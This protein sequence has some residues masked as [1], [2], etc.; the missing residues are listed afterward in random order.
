MATAGDARGSGPER[1]FAPELPERGPVIL[2]AEESAHLVRSRRV[3]QGEAV[4]LFDGRGTTVIGRLTTDDPRAAVVEVEGAYPGRVPARTVRLAV[5]LPEGGKADRLVSGLAE[6]GVAV[7]AP[8]VC[9]R[10]P[11]GRA[12]LAVRRAE[13]WARLARE[14]TKV[15]GCATMLTCAPARSLEACLGEHAMLLDPDPEAPRLV[16]TIVEDESPWVLVG[17]EGGFTDE[18]LAGARAVGA[19]IVRLGNLALRTETAALAAAAV[20]SA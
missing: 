20:L 17:P 18:E 4:V 8:L 13:R 1:A 9:A 10:T 14:A 19:R 6:L 3:R 11:P 16:E 2:D 7:F 5:S 12:D 15:N